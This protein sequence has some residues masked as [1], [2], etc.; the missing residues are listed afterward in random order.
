MEYLPRMIRMV[1]AFAVVLLVTPAEAAEMKRRIPR[2]LVRMLRPKVARSEDG[3]SCFSL[4]AESRQLGRI[5]D[6][7]I[8]TPVP[9]AWQEHNGAWL[10]ELPDVLKN[11]PR[12][13][14]KAPADKLIPLFRGVSTVRLLGGWPKNPN[15]V[16]GPIDSSCDLVYRK[17]DG[18]IGYRWARLRKRLDDFVA[19]DLD[20]LIVLDNVPYCF[21]KNARETK[22]GQV[23]GPDD[24]REYGTFIHD[25]CRELVRAYGRRTVEKWRFRIGTE[26]DLPG[27]WMD[28]NEAYCIMYDHV[29]HAIR[30]VLPKA[31]VGPGN[32]VLSMEPEMKA[33]PIMKHFA[34]GTNHATGQKGSPVDFLSISCYHVPRARRSY[35]AMFQ[36]TPD[37]VRAA[38]Y[39]LKQLR[40]L[41][42]RFKDIPIEIHEFGLLTSELYR[43]RKIFASNKGIR[44]A[45]WYLQ[46]HWTALDEGFSRVFSWG[47]ADK[48]LGKKRMIPHGAGWLNAMYELGSGGDWHLLGTTLGTHNGSEARAMASVQRRSAVIFMSVYN[49]MRNYDAEEKLRFEIG[50]DRLPFALP[51]EPRIEEYCQDMENG[52]IETIHGELKAKKLIQSGKDVGECFEPRFYATKEGRAY[53]RQRYPE[54]EKI[55]RKSFEPVPFRG[56][57]RVETNTLVLER[58]V[59]TPSVLVLVVNQ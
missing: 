41:S 12:F 47:L 11:A 55:V 42:P 56:S 43:D 34:S 46:A 51:R 31:P 53:L 26:P 3:V 28:S 32:F 10:H 38:A 27:H 20:M 13:R 48:S 6:F 15:F 36:H 16:F 49:L 52:V 40:S 35:D 39:K 29:A 14:G 2:D 22:Y 57:T 18:A 7:W 5:T 37:R 1:L 24:P 54:Y 30:S 50:L 25:L 21:V 44:Q 17:K 23:M 8:T 19:A 59:K 4:D 58:T 9:D 45:A 33:V